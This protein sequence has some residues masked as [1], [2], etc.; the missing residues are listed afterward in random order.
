MSVIEQKLDELG[1][2]LPA[3]KKPVANYIGTK[4]SG[5]LLFVSGRVS[6]ARGVVEVEVDLKDA[7][8]AARD[9]ILDLL[10]IIKADIGNLD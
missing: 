10:S 1:L 8:I 9:T 7:Q 3:P 6:E 2:S 5:N 4:Q